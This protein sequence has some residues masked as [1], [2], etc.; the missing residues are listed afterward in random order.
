M[1][2]A[3]TQAAL[4]PSRRMGH[5]DLTA[6]LCVPA[7]YSYCAIA[8]CNMSRGSRSS[9]PSLAVKGR[10]PAVITSDMLRLRKAQQ[11]QQVGT[12]GSLAAKDDDRL[13]MLCCQHL[14]HTMAILLHTCMAARASL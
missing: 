1:R 3:V 13:Y 8:D 14:F 9:V 6:L 2:D 12:Q 11:V 7:C 10:D 5:A 4:S